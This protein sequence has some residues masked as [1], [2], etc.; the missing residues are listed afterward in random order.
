MSYSNNSLLDVDAQVELSPI[1]F[2]GVYFGY[3]YLDV[4][5]DEDDV[6]IDVTFDGPY[7]GALLRF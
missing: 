5:F 2:V 6:A 7:A 1:P 3:R 4:D